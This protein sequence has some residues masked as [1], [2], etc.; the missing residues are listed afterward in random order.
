MLVWRYCQLCLENGIDWAWWV[1]TLN[2]EIIRDSSTCSE[3]DQ[4]HLQYKFYWDTVIWS[5]NELHKLY[6]IVGI[7]TWFVGQPAV[8]WVAPTE[9]GALLSKLGPVQTSNFSNHTRSTVD[10]NLISRT[11]FI[12]TMLT[13]IYIASASENK[14]YGNLCIRLDTWR[15][16]SFVTRSLHV[17]Q[18]NLIH[19]STQN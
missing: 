12:F 17:G 18:S 11:Q 14:L 7:V 10:L 9:F 13:M 8:S 15:V 4:G 16:P 5:D 19:R 2:Y 1:N 3:L 6:S